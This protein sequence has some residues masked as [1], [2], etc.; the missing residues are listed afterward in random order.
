MQKFDSITE[1]YGKVH[2][3]V[4]SEPLNEA[5]DQTFPKAG[6]KVKEPSTLKGTGPEEAEGYEEANLDPKNEKGGDKNHFNPKKHSQP[7]D[8]VEEEGINNSKN[9]KNESSFDNLFNQVM[10]EENPDELAAL[11]IDDAEGDMGGEDEFGGEGEEGQED[12][13]ITVS[14]EA[15]EA[16]RGVLAQLEPADEYEDEMDDDMG[17]EDPM[18]GVDDDEYDNGGGGFGEAVDAEYRGT[19]LHNQKKSELDNPAGNSNNKASGSVRKSG[20]K[21]SSA[22]SGAKAGQ[23]SEIGHPMVN[24]KKSELDNPAGKGNNKANGSIRGKGQDAF[25]S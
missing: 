7:Q 13:T 19:P 17:E 22:H 16:L 8:K 24:Q 15:A 4:P 9:M 12:I 14:P 10:N 11:G 3:Q 6:S 25:R 20:G 2:V 1:A 23:D 21:A 18:D 5:T